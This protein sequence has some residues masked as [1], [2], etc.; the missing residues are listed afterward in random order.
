MKTLKKEAFAHQGE[1]DN[2][3]RNKL[4]KDVCLFYVYGLP[5]LDSALYEVATVLIVLV[6]N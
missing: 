1:Q 4:I 5:R 6:N 3:S 2:Q